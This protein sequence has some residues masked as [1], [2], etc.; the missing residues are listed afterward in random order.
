MK[1]A[2]VYRVII[3][4]RSVLR[5]AF[6]SLLCLTLFAVSSPRFGVAP[7]ATASQASQTQRKVISGKSGKTG[8]ASTQQQA[9]ASPQSGK[10][11]PI[12]A[13]GRASDWVRAAATVCPTNEPITFGQTLRR[14]LATSDCRNPVPK[15]N[16]T[17]NDTFADEFT[18][19]GIRGQ[20]VVITMNAVSPTF[21]TYLYLLLP[22]GTLLAEN[23]D[24]SEAPINRNSRLPR[25]GFVTLPVSGTYSILASSFAPEELG[26]YDIT[27]TAGEACDS[28]EINFNETKQGELEANDCRNPIPLQSGEPDPTPVDFYTFQ[29][30]A[31][32]QI[33]ITMTALS[34]TVDPYIFLLLPNGDFLDINDFF[35]DDNGGGGTTARLPQGAGFGRLPM[36]G[37][38]TIVANTADNPNQLGTYSITLSKSATDC[39]STPISVGS[40]ASGTLANTDC[41][42]LEDG[43][44]IDAYTF[45][46]SAGD[47]V[48][49]TMNSTSATFAPLLYLLAPNGTIA[50]S[51]FNTEDDST[52]RIPGGTGLFTLPATGLYTILTNSSADSQSLT[53]NYTLSLANTV[54]PVCTYSLASSSQA[55]P[56]G[57]GQFTVGVTTQAGCAITATPSVSWLTVDSTSN[58]T[59]TYTVQQN[60][61]SAARS[62]TISI[63]G[64]TFTVNQDA[65]VCTY[66]LPE[67]SRTVSSGGGTF[68]FSVDSQPG[69][70]LPQPVSDSSWLLINSFSAGSNGTGTVSFTAQPNTLTVNR[71]GTITVGPTTYT[72][73]QTSAA[74]PPPALQFRL[75]TF[76]V[77]ENDSTRSATITVE[78]SG[79]TAGTATVEYATID[80]PASV[81]CDPTIRR[82]D[83]T[84]FPQGAAYARCDYSTSI[85]TLTFEARDTQKTFTIP[86]INDVHVEGAET[87]RI[88]LRNAQG[89]S[90][91]TQA[92]TTLTITDDDTTASSTNPINQSPFFVRQQYLD[93]LSREPD[94]GGFNA[95]LNAL[96]TCPQNIF[97]GPNQPS[98][99]DRIFVSGEGFFRSV[100]FQL[101]GL[102]VFLYYKASFGSTNNPNYVPQYEQFVP[103]IRRV[104]GQTPED[105]F[106]KRLKFSTDWVARTEFVNIYAS[107]SNTEFVN[108]LLANLGIA[109]TNPDP[110]SGVTRDSL[111][112]SL[113]NG[114]KQRA[115]VLRLIVESR[116][117]TA[118]Q[119]NRAFVAIQYYGYLR[120]TPEA[121]GYQ[122]WLNVLND[123]NLSPQVR[124]RTMINGFLNSPEYRLRFGPNVLQ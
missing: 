49:I 14:V 68:N 97:N 56:S 19:A 80:D 119:S 46:A 10:S 112:A 107:T 86:L 110:D 18:F 12:G 29:G 22:D 36:T 92:T 13:A 104:T 106:A 28:A 76:T 17:P 23:D 118:A 87:L 71:T 95:W 52:A 5:L 123:P 60:T 121:G 93:F 34:G 115:E 3:S 77:S 102:Y 83:G 15:P 82:P 55:A 24:A 78:R 58:N 105:V 94:E 27:L 114:S 40:T 43:S 79:D 74:V 39:P 120:R 91:G 65:L 20:Q 35:E 53:G 70:P 100:E 89:A 101:K 69:C 37:L 124:T 9:A 75:A 122:A 44:F 117:A 108:R 25:T 81:P 1:F 38:Y 98:G 63:N 72:I 30:T 61:T 21:D 96:N 99:C 32:Q 4:S 109:L 50:A 84:Q 57:G 33:S 26:T 64:Q 111:I 54:Q 62:G 88:E 103:D 51:D 2:N 42:L 31:G 90:L 6:L 8:T 48:S 47:Q 85:D 113:N 59:V 66:T 7:A 73:T 11:S 45:N 116:E 67:K 41:R 16:G